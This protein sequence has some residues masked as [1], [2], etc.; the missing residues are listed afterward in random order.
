MVMV[1]G[2]SDEEKQILEE[3]LEKN[4]SVRDIEKRHKGFGRTKIKNVIDRYAVLNEETA[5][6]VNLKRLEQK[7][8]REVSE[9]DID[10]DELTDEQVQ[11]AYYQIIQGE[12]TLTS[13]AGELGRNRDTLKG[14]IEEYLG[15]RESIAEFRDVLK[16]NQKVSKDRQRFFELTP[17]EKKQAI[18]LRLNYRRRLVGKN[19][20]S[21]ELLE[22]KYTR[23]MNYFH[24]R[25]SKMDDQE[26]ML[27]DEDILK[28]LYDFPTL[29]ATSIS[30]KVRPVIKLLDYKYLNFKDASKVLR[31]N[32]AILGTSMER[33]SLQMN[34]LKDTDT[35]KYALEKP[36]TFRTSPEMMYAL[37]GAWQAEKHTKSPF[38]T[39]K[40]A[41]ALYK[42]TPD[43][44][45]EAYDVTEEY[46][47]DEYF[48]GR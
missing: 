15:D 32:P 47:D 45:Q 8:H 13:L 30:S 38:I 39:L 28:M 5:L 36:R 27:S 1:T 21:E 48:D 25:N 16:R 7:Y 40:K 29:L 43:E 46:G 23:V 6:A 19:E 44:L 9:D 3:Y 35:L 11:S 17:E 26:A 34:I 24:K 37:I 14:A 31:E 41:E 20:Y 33:T 12:K 18:F 42:K 4:L 10:R 22:K 2:F